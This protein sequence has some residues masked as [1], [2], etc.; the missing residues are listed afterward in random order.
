MVIIQIFKVLTYLEGD[1][2][3]SHN[4]AERGF[5]QHAHFFVMT[6]DCQVIIALNIEYAKDTSNLPFIEATYWFDQFIVVHF[7]DES[8]ASLND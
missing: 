3:Y 8:F 7:I 5:L 6:Y 2:F 1:Q 4:T